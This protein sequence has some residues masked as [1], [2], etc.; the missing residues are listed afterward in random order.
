[1]G[2]TQ[3]PGRGDETNAGNG[4][5]ALC[6]RAPRMVAVEQVVNFLCELVDFALERLDLLLQ[7]PQNGALG[8]WIVAQG[9]QAIFVLGFGF[10]KI[11]A[12]GKALL[13]LMTNGRGW[14]PKF[15]RDH[16]RELAQ[17]SGINGIGFGPLELQPG[18]MPPA[19]RIDD[20]DTETRFVQKQS[21]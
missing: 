5:Q 10:V 2:G 12:Q 19:S 4:E 17:Q 8:V 20:T 21:E 16:L 1:M 18:K 9:L 15:R 6:S 7:P 13:Q 3:Q 14:C 11:R